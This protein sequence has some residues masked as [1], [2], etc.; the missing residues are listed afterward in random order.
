ML[1]LFLGLN[2]H[3]HLDYNH[4]YKKPELTTFKSEIVEL[5]YSSSLCCHPFIYSVNVEPVRTGKTGSQARIV[6]PV[7][8]G[9]GTEP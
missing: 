3:F 9:T 5:K 4:V 1:V 7:M 6:E 2:V 8:G